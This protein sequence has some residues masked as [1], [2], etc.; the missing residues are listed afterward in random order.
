MPLRETMIQMCSLRYDH[1]DVDI[2]FML[3]K[4]AKKMYILG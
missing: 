3:W 2:F 4:I 1:S